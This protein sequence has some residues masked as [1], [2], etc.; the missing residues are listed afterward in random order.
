MNEIP[1]PGRLNIGGSVQQQINQIIAYLERLADVLQ[2]GNEVEQGQNAEY[3]DSKL[4][5]EISRIGSNLV[6]T[7][8]NNNIGKIDLSCFDQRNDMLTVDSGTVKV[9]GV[10]NSYKTID[11]AFTKEFKEIPKVMVCHSGPSANRFIQCTNVTNKDFKVSCYCISGTADVNVGW[12]A[13]GK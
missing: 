4:V 3:D 13:I 12:T 7:K 11:I 1:R 10:S 2:K 6:I 9:T 8:A 5:K